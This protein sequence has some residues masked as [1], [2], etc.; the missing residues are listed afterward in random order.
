MTD[1]QQRLA[2]LSPEQR[3][4][5]EARLLKQN[6]A[7]PRSAAHTGEAAPVVLSGAQELFWAPGQPPVNHPVHNIA[8]AFRL[9][10]PLDSSALERALHTIVQRHKVLRTRVSLADGNPKAIVHHQHLALPITD[11]KAPALTGTGIEAIRW[12]REEAITPF[13]IYS[14]NLLLRARLLRRQPEEHILVVVLHRIAADATSLEVLDRELSQLYGAF[15]IGQSSPLPDLKSQYA[16]YAQEEAEWLARGG[17]DESLNYWKNQFESPWPEINLS[18]GG[19][20]PSER[21]FQGERKTLALPDDLVARVKKMS[22]SGGV[23]VYVPLLT[24]FKILLSE[25]SGERDIVVGAPINRRASDS[26]AK[27]M[28]NFDNFLP[29]RTD[30]SGDPTF[31]EALVRVQRTALDAFGAQDL[32]FAR[33]LAELGGTT[34]PPSRPLFNVV[35]DFRTERRPLPEL[36]ELSVEPIQIETGLS[37][38]DLSLRIRF[39]A[40]KLEGEFRFKTGVLDSAGIERMIQ[41]YE[42]ILA[43]ATEEPALKLSALSANGRCTLEIEHG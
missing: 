15:R 17:A 29:L 39:C 10:G 24:A 28:G 7:A 20:R 11:L 3:A 13:D 33:L 30:L 26:T 34:S 1:L 36:S 40:E 32:P 21:T 31:Q 4:L 27:L 38:F 22:A 23:P 42:T 35:F 2:S 9:C 8:Q 18:E 14:E 5:L 37:Q 12:V 16:D 19:A 25:L 43:R 6:T 41:S